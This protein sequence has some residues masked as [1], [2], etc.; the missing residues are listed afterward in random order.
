MARKKIVE[1]WLLLGTWMREN[2]STHWTIGL[3]YV[4]HQKNR[5]IGTSPFQALFGSAAYNGLEFLNLPRESKNK[6]KTASDLF[7]VIGKF[8]CYTLLN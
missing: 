4:Q 3:P 5:N 6:I 2:K 8:F 1:F 7:S